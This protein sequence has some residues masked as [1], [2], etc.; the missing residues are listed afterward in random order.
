VL[1]CPHPDCTA[2]AMDVFEV[3]TVYGLNGSRMY[4]HCPND[5]RIE[6]DVT[7]QDQPA[8]A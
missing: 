1:A 3:E 2:D 6:V 8:S 5:H 4:V 7:V